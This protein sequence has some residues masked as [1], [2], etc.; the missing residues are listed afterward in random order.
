MKK[1][2]VAFITV[3][4]FFLSAS[5]AQASFIGENCK[6]EKGSLS[7]VY[8]GGKTFYVQS[9]IAP[10][11]RRLVN[12]YG[13]WITGAFVRKAAV[14]KGKRV[15]KIGN[16]RAHGPGSSHFKGLGIDIVAGRSGW[17]GVDRAVKAL[18]RSRAVSQVLYNGS[19]GFGR[20]NHAHITYR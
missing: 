5:F 1:Y 4:V 6:K 10:S 11:V 17:N 9:K 16:P 18:K 3:G 14:C 12:N 8:S 20:G 13:V 19:P 2:L 15:S 7:K